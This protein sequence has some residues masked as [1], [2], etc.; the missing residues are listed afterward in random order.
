MLY[1]LTRVSFVGLLGIFTLLQVSPSA[2]IFSH[3]LNNFKL[4]SYVFA[5]FPFASFL[6]HFCFFTSSLVSQLLRSSIL[7]LSYE[8]LLL[9]PSCLNTST[10]VASYVSLP[11]FVTVVVHFTQTFL[12][13]VFSCPFLYGHT[14]FCFMHACF[15]VVGVLQGL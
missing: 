5:L 3:F 6:L 10:F 9:F 8:V 2:C 4:A 12:V 15:L 13:F 14:S 11:C 7:C 1:V